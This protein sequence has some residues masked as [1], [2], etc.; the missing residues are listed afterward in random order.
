MTQP[1]LSKPY[2]HAAFADLVTSRGVIPAIVVEG[3]PFRYPLGDPEWDG[4]P[5]TPR[6]YYWG[7]TVEECQAV[8]DRLNAERG[9]DRTRSLA[10]VASSL[11]ASQ[12]AL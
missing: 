2:V 11:R 1:D 10:I 3:D 6:P 8:C 7:S 5:S 4:D 9:I 12:V